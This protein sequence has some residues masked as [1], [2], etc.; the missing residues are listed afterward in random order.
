MFYIS[1]PIFQFK[2]VNF[3]PIIQCKIEMLLVSTISEV[4]F[5]K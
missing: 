5:Y 1:T 3:K 4:L 2:A